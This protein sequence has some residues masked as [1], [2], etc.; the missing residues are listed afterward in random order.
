MQR[1]TSSRRHIHKIIAQT[2][3]KQNG[4]ETKTLYMYPYSLLEK[5]LMVAKLVQN[6]CQEYMFRCVE[7]PSQDCGMAWK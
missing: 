5:T 7:I 2:Q 6:I 3:L 4:V 1:L